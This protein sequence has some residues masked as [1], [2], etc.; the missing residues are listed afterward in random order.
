MPSDEQLEFISSVIAPTQQPRRLTS[1]LNSPRRGHE[2]ATRCRDPNLLQLP[3]VVVF[4]KSAPGWSFFQVSRRARLPQ[5]TVAQGPGQARHAGQGMPGA[6]LL[7][8][9]ETV[10][11]SSELLPSSQRLQFGV[12]CTPTQRRP[13]P[14]ACGCGWQ[15]KSS[16]VE[17]Q[18]PFEPFKGRGGLP[19]DTTDSSTP[20][21][22]GL[23]CCQGEG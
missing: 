4:L 1:L 7:A 13:Q 10:R 21:C 2:A 5:P 9:V 3:A 19:L 6:L 18:W 11:A 12:P 17:N 14:R 20:R 23:H 22:S 8:F 15:C 16:G